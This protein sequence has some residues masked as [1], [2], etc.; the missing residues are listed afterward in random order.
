M[1]LSVGVGSD[2][3]TNHVVLL[4]AVATLAA[5]TLSDN[6]Q[7]H[8]PP[9][10]PTMTLELCRDACG[11]WDVLSLGAHECHCAVIVHDPPHDTGR[12]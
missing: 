11:D 10:P 2:S 3:L 4:L 7:R 8:P 6:Y 12:P 5:E 9:D 1:R